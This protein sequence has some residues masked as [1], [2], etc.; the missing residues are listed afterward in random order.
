MM[1]KERRKFIKKAWA[2]P[3]VFLLLNSPSIIKGNGCF[4]GEHCGHHCS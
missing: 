4:P 3:S 1:K 2:I